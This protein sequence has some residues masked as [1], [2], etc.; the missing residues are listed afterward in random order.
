MDK[1]RCGRSFFVAEQNAGTSKVDDKK[2]NNP[3]ILRPLK[4]NYGSFPS[5]KETPAV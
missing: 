3:P 5:Q 2:R 1:R 4:T